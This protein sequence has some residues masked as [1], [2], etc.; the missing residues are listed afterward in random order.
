MYADTQAGR[1]FN[2]QSSVG[3][4]LEIPTLMQAL[5]HEIEEL[6]GMVSSVEQRFAEFTS[7]SPLANPVADKLTACK[8]TA[9]GEYIHSLVEKVSGLR[10]RLLSLLERAE[11]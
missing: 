3:R 10:S 8:R 5:R 4:E 1:A 11:V 9:H 6:E 2:D 7:P